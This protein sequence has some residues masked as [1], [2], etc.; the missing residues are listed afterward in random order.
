MTLYPA[1]DLQDGRAVR[2]RQGDFAQTTVFSED[3]VD[4][5]RRFAADGATSLHV[6]DL[7]G[8]RAGEPVHAALVASI[9]AAFPGTVH[10]GGGLRS[11]AAIE[12]ALATGVDRVVV[13]T[14]VIDDRDLL[15]WAVDRLGDRLV[16]A[17]DARQ[18]KVATHG[19]TK[20]TDRDAIDVATGL[21]SMGVRHLAYTDI[22]RDGTLGGPNL[23]AMRRLADAAPPLRLI[24]SGGVSSLD[25]LR[26]VRDL[27]VATLD[28]VIVGRALYEGRFTVTEALDVLGAGSRA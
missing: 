25:D 2:L 27:G 7:D 21:L 20:V 13:G 17:L 24:A 14:A 12:T 22:N 18:G 5:A 9:A 8:A 16:V 10:L 1:I 19:W 15:A 6:V 3:P 28:G 4:Q 26:R 11:R 23:A